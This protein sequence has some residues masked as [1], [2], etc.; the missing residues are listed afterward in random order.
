MVFREDLLGVIAVG[1]KVS[2]EPFVLADRGLLRTLAN[3]S[4]IGIENAMAFDEIAKLNE[5]LEARVEE[6]TEELRETQN[7]L[8]QSEKMSALG[9]LVAG[10]AHEL[11]N[12][13]GFVHANLQLLDEFTS[14]LALRQAKGE[15]VAEVRENIARLLKRSREGTERVK[16]I[17]MDLRTFSRMD[18]AELQYADLHKEIDRTL[19]LMQPRLKNHI[20]VERIYGDVSGVYC[21]PG[22]LNQVF[23]N[24]LMNACD[25]L[26]S[27]GKITIVT[28]PSELGVRLE[29]RDN[30]PG[31][32]FEVQSRI[33]DPFFTTKEVGSGTGLGLS[34]S[35]GIIER[36]GGRFLVSSEPGQGACFVIDLP[37]DAREFARGSSLG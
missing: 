10:V 22:Q 1:R 24:L 15:D 14:E 13:I 32:P 11:N 8:M 3:Q 6:R 35:H 7:Q 31:I 9:Q 29:F 21:Y 26:E 20:E 23:L 17:V 37:L 33:F 36:H 25:S 28:T 2:S 18:Q 34:L 30:G 16:D 4:S 19:T 5:S 27:G 12:P